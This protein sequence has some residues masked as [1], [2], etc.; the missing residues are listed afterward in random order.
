[1]EVLFTTFFED[2]SGSA[3]TLAILMMLIGIAIGFVFG[4]R[5]GRSS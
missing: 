1:L 4:R 2:L 3:L 5:S